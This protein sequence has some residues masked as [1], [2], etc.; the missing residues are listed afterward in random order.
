M[1][2]GVFV[3]GQSHVGNVAINPIAKT[4][5]QATVQQPTEEQREEQLNNQAK[6]KGPSLLNDLQLQ[7]KNQYKRA[8]FTEFTPSQ[9]SKHKI[10]IQDLFTDMIM[11]QNPNSG[12][13]K[14]AKEIKI[15]D[16]AT[17]YKKK[18]DGTNDPKRILIQGELGNGKTTLM[19]RLA[20]SWAD[21]PNKGVFG[22][23]I[24]F[25]LELKNM[26]KKSFLENAIE[27]GLSN[28]E[29][30]MS[31]N[32]LQRVI[33]QN[34]EK[35][36]FL[37]DGY[38]ELFSGVRSEF[39]GVFKR[40][41]L[42][43]S[44]LVVTTRPDNMDELVKVCESHIKIR[45]FKPERQ[46]EYI[47]KFFKEVD[48]DQGQNLIKLRN[49]NQYR[50]IFEMA[51]TPLFLFYL[52]TLWKVKG[53]VPSTV[54]ELYRELL[55]CKVNQFLGKQEKRKIDNFSEINLEHFDAML[56]VG[57]VTL[58]GLFE[59]RLNIKQNELTDEK[60]TSVA[61]KLGL[62]FE[63][64]NVSE[65]HH[66]KSYTTTHKSESEFLASL[67][68]A[69]TM[70]KKSKSDIDQTVKRMLSTSELSQ[71]CKFTVAL[72]GDEAHL[73]MDY[74]PLEDF[75]SSALADLLDECPKGEVEIVKDSIK[76]RMNEVKHVTIKSQ[77]G[78]KIVEELN[79]FKEAVTCTLDTTSAN[80][81]GSDIPKALYS[82][83]ALSSLTWHG[84]IDETLE[85]F[86]IFGSSTLESLSKIS[87]QGK[88]TKTNSCRNL[89]SFLYNLKAMETLDL[90][91]ISYG[92]GLYTFVS[93]MYG[94]RCSG[95][96][97]SC[98]PQSYFN[99]MTT[100]TFV[101]KRTFSKG[102]RNSGY[103]YLVSRIMALCPSLNTV[104]T[105]ETNDEFEFHLFMILTKVEAFRDRQK[106]EVTTHNTRDL[107]SHASITLPT[108][109]NKNCV[110]ILFRKRIGIGINSRSTSTTLSL[111]IAAHRVDYKL[112]LKRCQLMSMP[113]QI[114]SYYLDTDVSESLHLSWY[115][116]FLP[117][118]ERNFEELKFIS[119]LMVKHK[120]LE[121]LSLPCEALNKD[122][123]PSEKKWVV[124][125]LEFTC[126]DINPRKDKCKEH[127][128]QISGYLL[129]ISSIKTLTIPPFR[130][131][132]INLGVLS[133]TE[134]P[135]DFLKLLISG[136]QT[137]C[138]E[139]SF[140]LLARLIGQLPEPWFNQLDADR[141]GTISFSL[142][143]KREYKG[144]GSKY[145][146]TRIKDGLQGKTNCTMISFCFGL[147][148]L[149]SCRIIQLVE[150]LRKERLHVDK[151]FIFPGLMFANPYALHI[152]FGLEKVNE[153]K[154]VLFNNKTYAD[155]HELHMV[156]NNSLKVFYLSGEELISYVKNVSGSVPVVR[157]HY[158]SN[159]KLNQVDKKK[160]TDLSTVIPNDS[161]VLV[162]RIVDYFD[163]P[164]VVDK[165]VRSC[166]QSSIS[167]RNVKS[168]TFENKILL[169]G[170]QAVT[171]LKGFP[172]LQKLDLSGLQDVKPFF[173]EIL[174]EKIL[175][176]E[177]LTEFCLG[178]CNLNFSNSGTLI[179]KLLLSFRNLQVFKVTPI[180]N[181]MSASV[182]MEMV[183]HLDCQIDSIHKHLRVLSFGELKFEG[184]DADKVG[185][186]FGRLLFQFPELQS[187]DM[188]MFR[189]GKSSLHSFITTLIEH[190]EDE[191]VTYKLGLRHLD[192]SGHN[193]KSGEMARFL[194]AVKVLPKLSELRLEMCRI[195]DNPGCL[196]ERICK[197][198]RIDLSRCHFKN[199][200]HKKI[201]VAQVL[202]SATI[203]TKL[204][205]VT[206]NEG[207]LNSLGEELLSSGIKS[208]LG[209]LD[210]SNSKLPN[211]NFKVLV[212]SLTQLKTLILK[213][214]DID[215]DV[216]GRLVTAIKNDRCTFAS[217]LTTLDMSSSKFNE[218]ASGDHLASVLEIFPELQI[219]RL[220]SCHITEAV[221]EKF[222]MELK[223]KCNLEL[224]LRSLVL[225][226]NDITSLDTVTLQVAR[227]L[228]L[229]CKLKVT[230]SKINVDASAII[231]QHSYFDLDSDNDGN[232]FVDYDISDNDD[233]DDS[234]EENVKD[235]Y[236]NFL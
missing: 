121:S 107:E 190:H 28:L 104:N 8:T 135:L 189:T 131:A 101:L 84:I 186:M 42:S 182:F 207:F 163:S 2:Q 77:T 177:I 154:M 12:N 32:V 142:P 178:D 236:D 120:R 47:D 39:E 24:V 180:E 103:A 37:C 78:L 30:L 45:G 195:Y 51:R 217:G 137:P 9:W 200:D 23:K 75:K 220:S 152:I 29:K 117:R 219:L 58:N 129:H 229:D 133:T 160:V 162:F 40:K 41:E 43:E 206:S 68:V 224:R 67:Y 211:V 70:K 202:R 127:M 144:N 96:D 66:M 134:T 153:I 60:Q 55:V 118:K 215:A 59:N 100:L 221:M 174:N 36:V 201:F 155:L 81:C 204:R 194:K 230:S 20:R 116:D 83:T 231:L 138:D 6:E 74:F 14:K 1:N 71:V 114:L 192:L 35:F 87:L 95:D 48:P 26:Q 148:G 158:L 214:C 110:S 98:R 143:T 80:I 119:Q 21:D 136:S 227:Y 124:K 222:L 25:F 90:P 69:E 208:A 125:H 151:F 166:D 216:L 22:E 167:C 123:I 94:H 76:E 164:G 169:K 50:H 205:L 233:D 106:P 97:P 16:I 232:I 93:A 61:S 157:Q 130:D 145:T 109:D 156:K 193:F 62:I 213:D 159:V 64:T 86:P 210:L 188:S 102:Q 149:A 15:D 140:E 115:Q 44:V 38:D 52:C 99:K 184:V 112:Q 168:L 196:L 209:Y 139:L 165:M 46:D 185:N 65:L 212:L 126:K 31:K 27:I 191:T 235:D 226:D 108:N 198:S 7:L 105:H 150:Q 88:L 63:E 49:D 218:P 34:D 10:D 170:T 79:N 54:I 132:F 3:S 91:V 171:V 82:M 147:R 18:K 197:F 122:Q 11:F 161:D 176:R 13:E 89:G 73:F 72:L 57:R 19:K 5:V 111:H 128:T 228:P 85:N 183:L 187:L 199:A 141:E 223:R 173:E 113:V 179:A 172:N 234:D 33:I 17:P 181:K 92:P 56:Y 4:F 53:Q 175:S 225:L 146:V 203:D